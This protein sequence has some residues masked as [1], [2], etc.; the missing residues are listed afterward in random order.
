MK[1]EEKFLTLHKV[2]DYADLLAVTPNHLNDT[3]KKVTGKT[4]LELIQD[5]LLLEAKRLL[6]HTE[7][8][9]K[10]ISYQ[11]GYNDPSYFTRFFK[12]QTERTP[13]DFRRQ[14]REKY[15]N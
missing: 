2:N 10:E 11:L 15:H 1:V 8:T 14:I 6:L 13:D 9:A 3:T 4:A 7:Q 5:R 12:A